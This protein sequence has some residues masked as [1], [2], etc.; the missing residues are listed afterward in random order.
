M[1]GRLSNIA[2]AGVVSQ[3]EGII[4]RLRALNGDSSL[5]GLNSKSSS[6]MYP[7]VVPSENVT[8]I[9]SSPSCATLTI[10]IMLIIRLS[11]LKRRTECR[12]ILHGPER[13]W[14]HARKFG[15]LG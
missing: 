3:F 4:M 11:Y 12:A 8:S 2:R 13:P 5:M 9:P 7:A 6:T 14:W 15:F 1:A 10:L